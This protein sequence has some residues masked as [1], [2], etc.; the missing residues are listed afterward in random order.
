MARNSAGKFFT[1]D[2]DQDPRLT[3]YGKW[4]CQE[5]LIVTQILDIVDD[6]VCGICHVWAV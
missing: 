5:A 2:K 4:D 1:I 6:F 3:R